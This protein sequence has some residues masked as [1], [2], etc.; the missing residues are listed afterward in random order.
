MTRQTATQLTKLILIGMGIQLL[1]I[2]YVFYQS[3]TGRVD[4]VDS[5]RSGCVRGKADRTANALG[6]R[7]AEAARRAAGEE[8]VADIYADIAASLEKRSRID[9]VDAYPNPGFLP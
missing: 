9:C 5:Q 6:W 2:G 1:V 7:N 8:K 4:L 3:Y